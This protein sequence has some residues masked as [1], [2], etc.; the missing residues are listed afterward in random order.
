MLILIRENFSPQKNL[1][2]EFQSYLKNSVSIPGLLQAGK[3]ISKIFAIFFISVTTALFFWYIRALIPSLADTSYKSYVIWIDSLI[4]GTVP[5]LWIQQN[6]RS[7]IL[8]VF[9]RWVWLSYGFV[10]LFGSPLAYMIKAD[11]KRHLLAVSFTL[12]LG[13]FIHYLFPTQ[14]PW[15]AINEVQRINGDIY[16]KIDKNLTAAMPSIHQAIIFLAGCILWKCGLWGKFFSITYNLLMAIALVYLGEHYFIDSLA[17]ILISALSWW[18][19]K[20][21]G[22]IR[23]SQ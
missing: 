14:P 18:F 15:M 1:D 19:A 22:Y 11:S 20:K 2:I 13:L 16:S 10:I 12:F 6:Y 5:S 8:D 9:F 17:G 7:A 21:F 3:H 4:F 23:N